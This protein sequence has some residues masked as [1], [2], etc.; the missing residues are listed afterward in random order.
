MNTIKSFNDTERDSICH[1]YKVERGIIRSAGKF[2][3]EPVYAPYFYENWNMGG[4]DGR[5]DSEEEYF[6]VNSADRRIFPELKDVYRVYIWEDDNGFVYTA[7][8]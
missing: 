1:E 6:I 8:A 4:A 2:E 7:S 3:N 5:N